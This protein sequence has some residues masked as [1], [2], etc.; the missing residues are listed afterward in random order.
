MLIRVDKGIYSIFFHLA[1]RMNE[2]NRDV[3]T[4]LLGL[5]ISN[6]IYCSTPQ[7]MKV[8]IMLNP[9]CLKENI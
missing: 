2:E 9:W 6:G 4:Q 1:R 3:Y 5:C 8:S 7:E